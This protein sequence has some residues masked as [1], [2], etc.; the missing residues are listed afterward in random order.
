MNPRSLMLTEG[1]IVGVMLA[2]ATKVSFPTYLHYI[3]C[4]TSLPEFHWICVCN[5]SDLCL[6]GAWLESWPGQCLS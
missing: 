5:A 6:G 3:S 2:G 1:S 4:T